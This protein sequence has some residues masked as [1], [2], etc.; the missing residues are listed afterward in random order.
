MT[1]YWLLLKHH[2]DRMIKLIRMQAAQIGESV[3]DLSHYESYIYIFLPSID[4]SS[5]W[6][7]SSIWTHNNFSKDPNRD[8][9]N[10]LSLRQMGLLLL[11]E[12]K[13]L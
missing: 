12:V 2:I 7:R 6:L 1:I 3:N 10:P 9:D 13:F 5:L 4:W 11:D 8:N